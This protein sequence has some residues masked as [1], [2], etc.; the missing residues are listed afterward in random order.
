M[1]NS[2]RRETRRTLMIYLDCLDEES[3]VEVG[4][5][6]DI[7]YDG[8]MLM[9]ENPIALGKGSLYRIFLPG[10]AAFAGKELKSRGICRW[11]RKDDLQ[12]LYYMGIA[13]LNTGELDQGVIDLLI[14]RIGFSN[15]QK[16]IFTAA[17][18]IE[19]K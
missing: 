15:G 2:N 12:E 17:G 18:D 16:K 5:I 4:K 7:T 10:T 1:A 14:S 19:Y 13:F 6:V 8:F 3:K 11:V 9:S